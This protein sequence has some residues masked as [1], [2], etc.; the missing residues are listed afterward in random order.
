VGV[1]KGVG[2]P[3]AS[4][5]KRALKGRAG[6]ERLSL[7]STTA[8]RFVSV[9]SGSEQHR[10]ST[11]IEALRVKELRRVFTHRYS[12]TLP[13]DDAGR[14]DVRLM[15]DHLAF[16]RNASF[17]ME[18][19]AAQW[20]PWLSNSERDS[21]MADAADNGRLPS[22]DSVAQRL[23]I[24]F[25]MRTALDLR[26]IGSVDVDKRA[27]NDLQKLRRMY[28]ERQRRADRKRDRQLLANGRAAGYREPGRAD[29][30]RTALG[31]TGFWWPVKEIAD[32]VS[33]WPAFRTLDPQ[34]LKRVIRREL[35]RL[36]DAELI[37]ELE[38]RPKTPTGREERLFRG[39]T[40]V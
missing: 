38:P 32:A 18:D 16:C 15:F 35:Q 11:G 9:Y 2:P 33:E 10:R 4:T 3:V 14:D 27:R 22:A 39:R 25:A 21:M 5:T 12:G 7:A 28:R 29:A 30:I 40:D 8:Q 26:S 19:F 36:K 31:V 17:L 34:S 24:G 23:Q 37:E 13:D 1:R 20:A 6:E